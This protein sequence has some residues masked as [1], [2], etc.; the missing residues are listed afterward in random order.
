MP[1]VRS[2]AA[3]ASIRHSLAQQRARQAALA[4]PA[5]P[6]TDWYEQQLASFQP[7]DSSPQEWQIVRPMWL[8]LMRRSHIRG[9]RTFCQLMSELSLY[10]H[11]HH[12]TGYELTLGDLLHE[13]RIHNWVDRSDGAP[14]TRSNR[15]SRLISL[16]RHVHPGPNARPKPPAIPRTG[17]RAPY[18]LRQCAELLELTRN[19][20]TATMRRQL[21]VCVCTGLGAG[22][23][24]SD[25]REFRPEYVTQ[26]PDQRV[27]VRFVGARPRTVP[28]DPPY[29]APLLAALADAEAGKLLLGRK[30]DRTAITAPVVN[31]LTLGPGTVRPEQARMRS[32]WLLRQMTSPRLLRGL[33]DDAGLI[34]ARTFTDLLPYAHDPDYVN[35]HEKESS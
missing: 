23:G 18:T 30:T 24:P 15:R 27:E 26:R 25:L 11:H 1:P 5:P 29:D 12:R 32:T 28:V 31:N 21:T 13:D 2:R 19:L 4:Q 8:D 9:E 14:S 35:L 33:L 6:L 10:L 7:K 22:A 17:V 20:P 16:A 34:S 3:R